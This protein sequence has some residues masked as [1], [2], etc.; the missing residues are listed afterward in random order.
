[1][2]QRIL[3]EAVRDPLPLPPGPGTVSDGLGFKTTECEVMFDG[4]PPPACGEVFVAIHEGE[5]ANSATYDE[6]RED[7]IGIEIT[8][9]RRTGFVPYDRAVVALSDEARALE[10]QCELIVAKVHS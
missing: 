7:F 10:K 3:A 6:G 1:M 9:T 5:W 4:Q 2:S 8:V